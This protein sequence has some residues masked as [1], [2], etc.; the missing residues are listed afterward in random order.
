MNCGKFLKR[1]EYQISLPV[2]W[3]TCMQDKKQQLEPDMKQLIGCF[4]GKEVHQGSILSPCL[5]NLYAEYIMWN[6]SLVAQMVKNL[7]AVQEIQVWFLSQEDPLESEW[8]E[9][10]QLCL[11]LCDLWTARR[12]N[13]SMLKEINPEYSLE[14]LM[15]KLKLQTLATWC[16]ELTH[17]ERP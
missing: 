5:F 8:S 1:W 6:T 7:P 17:W 12:S 9:V 15:L 4:I 11:T 16:K 13:Q 2:S 14:G 10:T 3:E